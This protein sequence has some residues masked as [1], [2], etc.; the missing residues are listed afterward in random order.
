[1]AEKDAEIVWKTMAWAAYDGDDPVMT[2]WFVVFVMCCVRVV[3]VLVWVLVWVFVCGCWCVWCVWCVCC[4]LWC[5]CCVCVV[6][7]VA[8]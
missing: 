4:C 2:A 3:C 6:C 8:R 1:M 7:G 5:V